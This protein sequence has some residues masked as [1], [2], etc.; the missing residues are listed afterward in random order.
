MYGTHVGH[1]LFETCKSTNRHE[2]FP[3]K[4]VVH[5]FIVFFKVCKKHQIDVRYFLSFS[6][7]NV[8]MH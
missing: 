8:Y 2:E 3:I 6:L 1:D 4:T 7:I 5:M